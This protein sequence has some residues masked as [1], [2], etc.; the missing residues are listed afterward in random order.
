MHSFINF[1]NVRKFFDFC[2]KLQ[3]LGVAFVVQLFVNITFD[4][5]W[6][7]ISFNVLSHFHFCCSNPWGQLW[8]N[9]KCKSMRSSQ[10]CEKIICLLPQALVNGFLVETWGFSP[11]SLFRTDVIQLGHSCSS[12]EST[13][14]LVGRYSTKTSSPH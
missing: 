6:S 11:S 1:I 8:S 7:I 2:Q 4:K 3:W 5:I 14:L 12:T 13:S 10:H 9:T